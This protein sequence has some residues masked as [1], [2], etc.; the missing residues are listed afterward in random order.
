MIESEHA[1]IAAIRDVEISRGVDRQ[2][3]RP[4][5]AGQARLAGALVAFDRE[6]V[7]LADY[8]RDEVA[9]DASF[10]AEDAVVGGI[11]DIDLNHRPVHANGYARFIMNA[12]QFD[13]VGSGVDE[14]LCS[15]LAYDLIGRG[16]AG[17]ALENGNPESGRQRYQ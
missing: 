14:T 11:R 2:R 7:V 6:G 16:V 10:R 8:D 17:R 15:R 5:E 13:K 1:I 4:A 12:M 3:R 9:A